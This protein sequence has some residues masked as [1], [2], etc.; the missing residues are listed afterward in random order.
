MDLLNRPEIKEALERI[1]GKQ[2]AY[3]NRPITEKEIE[4]V[5]K[6]VMFGRAVGTTRGIYYNPLIGGGIKDHKA[7]EE[8]DKIMKEQY[9]KLIGK[10]TDLPEPGED[11]KEFRVDKG[12]LGNS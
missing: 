5:V 6:D 4:D 3:K 11:Q 10:Y 2:E 12:L 1:K 8:F 9:A 7:N